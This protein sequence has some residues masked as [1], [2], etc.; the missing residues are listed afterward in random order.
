[1]KAREYKPFAERELKKFLRRFEELA[2][3]NSSS[4]RLS[5]FKV[6][7]TYSPADEVMRIELS[8]E[9]PPEVWEEIESRMPQGVTMVPAPSYYNPAIILTTIVDP[10]DLIDD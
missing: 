6:S 2:K 4:L 8:D 3:R 10:D 9:A 7:Y 5:E 1:M